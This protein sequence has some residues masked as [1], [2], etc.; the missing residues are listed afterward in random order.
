MPNLVSY[1]RYEDV[2]GVN[3]N[4]LFCEVLPTHTTSEDIFIKLN[5]FV[6]EH[7]VEWDK[8]VGLCTDGA[9]AMVGC[10]AGV[11]GSS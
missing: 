5:G 10:H 1:V 2:S 11:V 6:N 4:M 7:Y 3:E 9:A 8:C